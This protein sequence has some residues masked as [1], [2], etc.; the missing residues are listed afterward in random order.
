[1]SNYL[2]F[3][4]YKYEGDS[5]KKLFF[6]KILNQL[7]SDYFSDD[8]LLQQELIERE[9]EGCSIIA[10]GLAMPHIVSTSIVR[11]VVAVVS[12]PRSFSGWYQKMS[13]DTAI[14]LLVKEDNKV[15]ELEEIQNI[16]KKLS[17]DKNCEFIRVAN[18][19]EI[20]ELLMFRK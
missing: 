17:I 19:E 7:G 11:N 20:E 8:V 12:I 4:Y 16:V 10:D 2:D 5:N 14:V 15:D 3:Y 18:V 13:V 9:D 6:E 1:M